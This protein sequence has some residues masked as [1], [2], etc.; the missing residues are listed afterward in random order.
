[1][2]MEKARLELVE[3]GKKLVT[4]NLTKGTGGNLSVYDRAA[5]TVAITPSGI[6]FFEIT[7]EDIVIID[8]DG[9]TIEGT[10]TP[11]SEWEMHLMP[12]RHR[13]DIDAVIHA[14]TTYATVLA[15]L[16]QD[17][18]PSHYMVEVAGHNVRCAPYA[19]YG[20]HEL[21]VNANE[22]MKDRRAVLLANHGILA[23]ANDLLNAFNIIEEVEYC[24]QIHWMASCMGKPVILPD[25][26]MELMAEKFKTYGQ[27]KAK[28]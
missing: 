8:L 19:T 22:Y 17:L 28:D 27:R 23:G 1:M 6:D 25:E 12:Y 14:H 4:S 7:P 16:R 20:S 10:R 26:E 21:A 5:G 24:S 15:V 11:S 2:L 18:P 13:T 9:K 3:F